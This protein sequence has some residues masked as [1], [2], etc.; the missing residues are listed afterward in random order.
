MGRAAAGLQGWGVARGKR[1]GVERRGE[2]KHPPHWEH[3]APQGSGAGRERA[4][5][6]PRERWPQKGHPTVAMDMVTGVG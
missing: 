5:K 1:A 3:K 4:S 6:P 2:K